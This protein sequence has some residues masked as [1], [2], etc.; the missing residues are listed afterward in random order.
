M[1]IGDKIKGEL[2]NGAHYPASS[3]R[4]VYR[5][6]QPRLFKGEGIM[7]VYTGDNGL[8]M[9]FDDANDSFNSYS[10]FR[11]DVIKALTLK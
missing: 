9:K 6:F 4:K 8:L 11:E 3:T 5:D 10:F 2:L 1:Q 7:L